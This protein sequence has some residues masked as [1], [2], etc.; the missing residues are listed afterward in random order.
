[1][2][3]F[4]LRG[5]ASFCPNLLYLPQ[6]ATKKPKPTQL[7]TREENAH[8]SKHQT[9]H[10]LSGGREQNQQQNLEQHESRSHQRQLADHRGKTEQLTEQDRQIRRTNRHHGD[11]QLSIFCLSCRFFTYLCLF[12]RGFGQRFAC[13]ALL[14]CVHHA[15]HSPQRYPPQS[16]NAG[17]VGMGN[18]F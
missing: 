3:F 14:D 15:P 4:E 9:E 8:A 12:L 17:K 16:R 1:M 5:F 7:Q 6:V 10:H 2:P 18:F 13:A 11:W